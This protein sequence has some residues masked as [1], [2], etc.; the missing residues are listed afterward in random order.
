M[1]ITLFKS[2][3]MPLVKMIKFKYFIFL[4]LNSYFLMLAYKLISLSLYKT[5]LI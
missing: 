3:L 5:F 4:T 1:I 2:I